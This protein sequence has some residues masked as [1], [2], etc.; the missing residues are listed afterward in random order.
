MGKSIAVILGLKDNM[1]PK[2]LKVKDNVKKLNGE[3]ARALNAANAMA[4]GFVNGCQ[5]MLSGAM[6]L[7]T[8]AAVALAGI[9]LAEAFDLETYKQ[10]LV[11]FY[12]IF[13]LQEWIF[14]YPK[15]LLHSKMCQEVF[16]H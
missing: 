8:G 1:S 7:A 13:H 9:G 16:L 15:H 10:Q 3:Q 4:D 12:T 5:R 2:L 11:M 6:K 14:R